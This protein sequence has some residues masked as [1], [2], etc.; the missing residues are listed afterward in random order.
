MIADAA[1][2][3]RYPVRSADV[4]GLNDDPGEKR[5][6]ED[7][8]ADLD[9]QDNAVEDFLS[10][11]MP[12]LYVKQSSYGSGIIDINQLA[13]GTPGAGK[14]P[15]GDPPVWTDVATQDELNAIASRPG[16]PGMDGLDGEEG[17]QGPPG[18]PGP[19][20][21][22][23]TGATGATGPQGLQGPPGVDG[24]DGADGQ[25]GLRG[26]PGPALQ[27]TFARSLMLMG[28]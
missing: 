20:G 11:T 23:T 14:A 12:Q 17:P 15:V 13:S 16:I 19:A 25:D 4:W 8:A 2:I 6:D 21:T 24:L 22:G 7:I 5:S 27:P 28:A 9:F 1:A 26:P 10:R 3:F 18:P